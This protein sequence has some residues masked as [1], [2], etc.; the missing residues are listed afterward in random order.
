MT[1][2]SQLFREAIIEIFFFKNFEKLDHLIKPFLRFAREKGQPLT[3][4]QERLCESKVRAL[5]WKCQ[6]EKIE[7]KAKKC[8]E[9]G[10][11]TKLEKKTA[12]DKVS[13]GQ[14]ET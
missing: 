4:M 8:E 9:I 6:G 7:K 10:N 13:P 14:V 3:L 11:L 1:Q 12:E 2:T 5:F